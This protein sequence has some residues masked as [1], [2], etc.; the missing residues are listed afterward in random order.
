M[1]GYSLLRTSQNMPYFDALMNDLNKLGIPIEGIHT[2]TGPGVYEAAIEY[3]E[4][5]EAADR[6]AVFKAATKGTKESSIQRLDIGRRFGIM[7]S[8][9][10][11][12][13]AN[14]PGCGGHIHLNLVDKKTNSNAFFDSSDPNSMV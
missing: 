10:A 4:A 3:G 1:F 8:F 6:A 7:P 5:V 11:K 9:M 2:E 12:P 13:N 14:L